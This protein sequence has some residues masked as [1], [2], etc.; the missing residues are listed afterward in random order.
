MAS[1]FHLRIAAFIRRDFHGGERANIADQPATGHTKHKYYS[2]LVD[3]CRAEGELWTS[4]HSDGS[5]AGRLYALAELLTLRSPG[6]DLAES[7]PLYSF[8]R[9]RIHVALL[10]ASPYWRS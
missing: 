9:A 6:S 1:S 7:R 10:V 2:H 8:E 5:G 3:G 4:R